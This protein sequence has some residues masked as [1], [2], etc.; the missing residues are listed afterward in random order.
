MRT[1][2]LC[3]ATWGP[4]SDSVKLAIFILVSRHFMALA[5]RI[6]GC[7]ESQESGTATVEQ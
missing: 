7:V 5:R 6:A 2:A 1:S 3:L 4:Q